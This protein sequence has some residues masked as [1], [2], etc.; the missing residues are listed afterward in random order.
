[1]FRCSTRWAGTAWRHQTAT[2]RLRCCTSSR[3]EKGLWTERFFVRTV[4]HNYHLPYFTLSPT[5]SVC[6]SHGYLKG[7]QKKCPHCG[8][9]VETYSRV[10]GYLRPV[11]QWNKGKRAEFGLRSRYHVEG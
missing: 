11:D 1:M 3:L 6:P 5:F 9:P 7:E 2:V 4:C 10:V 8:E